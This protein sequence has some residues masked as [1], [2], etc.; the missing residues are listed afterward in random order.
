[1][2]AAR[3]C[4]AFMESFVSFFCIFEDYFGVI[5]D[6]FYYFLIVWSQDVMPCPPKLHWN[7]VAK[8]CDWPVN[9]SCSI[10]SV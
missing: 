3:F 8:S 5:S 6:V 4:S 10:S 2:T 9:T 1:V 7:D